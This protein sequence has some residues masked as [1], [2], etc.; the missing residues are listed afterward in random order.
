MFK[1]FSTDRSPQ[2]PQED[3]T[4]IPFSPS[5]ETPEETP[6]PEENG[7]MSFEEVLAQ[8]K[9]QLNSDS[10]EESMEDDLSP[11]LEDILSEELSEAEEGED[12]IGCSGDP[13]SETERPRKP[14]TAAVRFSSAES[15]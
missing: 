7:V 15:Q 10:S 5:G 6:E 4:R 13:P 11:L 2:G 14:Q 9:R 1:G 8:W 12:C 3:R